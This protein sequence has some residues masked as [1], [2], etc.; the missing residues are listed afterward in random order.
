MMLGGILNEII[1]TPL[2]KAIFLQIKTNNYL[3]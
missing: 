2:K 3:I 1:S